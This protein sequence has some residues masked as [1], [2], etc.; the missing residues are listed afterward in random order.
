LEIK[1][2][3]KIIWT[4]FLAVSGFAA[5]WLFGKLLLPCLLPFIFAFLTAWF[6]EPAVSFLCSRFKMKRGFASAVCSLFIFFVAGG[7]IALAVSRLVYEAAG[8]IKDLPKLLQWVPSSLNSLQNAL[9]KYVRTAPEGTREYI[10]GAIDSISQSA[11]ELPAVLSERA[12]GLVSSFASNAP[13]IVLFGVTYVIGVFFIS[14]GYRDIKQFLLRQIPGKAQHTARRLKADLSDGFISWLKAQLCLIGITFGELLI[15]LSLL[16]FR[17]AALFSLLIAVVDA[18][19][20][21][22]TGTVLLPWAVVLFLSGDRFG[23]VGLIVTYCV[24]TV[25]RSFL[26]PKLVGGRFGIHPAAAL[27]AIYSGFKIWGVGG[28]VLFPIALIMLKQIND[29]GYVKLW[30]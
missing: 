20:V 2:C 28:M 15:A 23:A 30:K 1:D 8:F 27:L 5:L 9:D 22:G 3:K 25:A 17:Y 18:F 29:K 11:V 4:A 21:L 10:S 6:L 24:V 26:E 12:L 16:G 7:V 19:P 13:G 14:R